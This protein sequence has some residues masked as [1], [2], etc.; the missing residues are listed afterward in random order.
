MLN[1]LKI[2]FFILSI[3]TIALANIDKNKITTEQ[4]KVLK[5]ALSLK[6]SG[7]SNEAETV[8]KNLFLKYPFLKE[9]LDPLKIILKEKKDWETLDEVALKFI[10][11]NHNSFK[12]QAEIIDIYIWTKNEQWKNIVKSIH[13][14][15]NISDKT[16]EKVL[17]VL[18]NTNKVNE[19]EK[20]IINLRLNRTPDYFAFNYGLY[21]SMNMNIEKS[22]EEYLLYLKHNPSKKILI[23][24]RIM[25]LPDIES[26]TNKVKDVLEKSDFNEAKLLLSDIYFKN[27]DYIRS[28][29]L[30]KKY[31]NNEN[32][33]IELIKNLVRIK[34][35]E[36][37]QLVIED[38][39]KSSSNKIILNKAVMQLAKVYENLFISNKYDMPI[40][41]NIIENQL[42]HSNFIKVNEDNSFLLT[43]AIDIYDSLRTKNND[44]EATYYLAE[45]KYRVLGDLDGSLKLYRKIIDNIKSSN[46]KLESIN[47]LLDISIA[48]GD[49]EKTL[50]TIDEMKKIEKSNEIIELLNIKKIQI[51]FYLND[52]T[53]LKDLSDIILKDNLKDN[54]FYNDVLK[55]NTNILLFYNMDYELNKYSQAM[56]KLFQNKRTEAIKILSSIN[57]SESEIN[58]KIAYELSYLYLIQ[59][60]FDKAIITIDTINKD[61]AFS[62]S[63]L[64]LKAEIFDY[65][66][67]DKS[68]A[69]EIYLFLL[70][71][72]PDSIHYEK[73]RLRLRDLAS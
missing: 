51:F 2:S 54:K 21:N 36:L 34:E 57:S 31:S 69:V 39:I 41:N 43:R 46:L 18:M 1:K 45:I 56:L 22:V 63:A 30:L 68:K 48:K 14:N 70:D 60:Q 6:K 17:K 24:N 50:I 47:R 64:L 7:L 11:A 59:N 12:S 53:N 58:D 71:N 44:N 8:Y 13:D 52:Y 27:N 37:A 29:E 26:I 9:A 10:N 38:I 65:I 61:S 19:L 66:L 62:E 73:I 3:F 49:L 28:Y 4:K 5:Q 72:F 16:I 20:L 67:N 55:I 25:A 42:L 32:E 40:T 23:R 35:F 33:K 15:K